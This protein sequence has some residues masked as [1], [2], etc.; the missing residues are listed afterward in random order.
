MFQFKSD[1]D[2]SLLLLR[3]T[4]AFWIFTKLFSFNLW[5]ADRLFPVVPP[6]EFLENVPNIIHLALFYLALAGIALVGIFPKQKVILGITIAVELVSCLLD[7]SRWQ[8]WEYQFLLT[9]SFFFFYHKKPKQFLTYFSFL[10]IVIYFQSGLHKLCGAFLYS[11]WEQ[12]V[13]IKFFGFETHQVR[14]IFVHY[15]G[16]LLGI[17]EFALALG[18][19]LAKNKKLYV[20][21]LLGM[22]LFVLVLL[23]PTGINYNSIIWPWNIAMI[24]F[25]LI[26]F[27]NTPTRIVFKDLTAGYS[28]VYFVLLGVLPFFSFLDLFDNYLSFNL[29]SGS[30]KY[31]NICVDESKISPAYHPY[32]SEN[33]KMCKDVKTISGN[34]WAL[35]EMNVVIYP[36]ERFYKGII[37]QW[38]LQN[39]DSEATFYIY[40][41][42]YKPENYVEYK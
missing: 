7:Q 28:K 42:P 26:T 27:Y 38:K 30:T 5:H 36:E 14:N 6:F 29:Y 3:I 37:K 19:L 41:Y 20:L 4:C 22:H 33:R 8:P 24:L 39:P 2:K 11:V 17:I 1:T 25:V 13:L 9:Y 16:L 35:E 23:S 10:L 32:L 15:A 34:D 40:Q 18:C 12:M 31:F 21:L